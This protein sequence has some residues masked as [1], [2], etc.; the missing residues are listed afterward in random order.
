VVSGKGWV[1]T[2]DA[3]GHKTLTPGSGTIENL[4]TTLA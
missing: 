3:D 2:I 1:V 4:C